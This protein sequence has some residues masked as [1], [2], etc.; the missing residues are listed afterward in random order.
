MMKWF[1]R[2][3]GKQQG[4]GAASEVGFDAAAAPDEGPEALVGA[5]LQPQPEGE[6]ED[7]TGAEEDRDAAESLQDGPAATEREIPERPESGRFFKRL[8][9]RFSGVSV[10]LSAC[11][12]LLLTLG[13]WLQVSANQGL[14]TLIRRRCGIGIPTSDAAPLPLL[15]PGLTFEPFHHGC[16][17]ILLAPWECFPDESKY[18]TQMRLQQNP[19]PA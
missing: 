16:L 5:D 18:L 12:V 13:L 4:D 19:P 6:Q 8:R 15:F 2:K 9:Q 17:D 7:L 10:F 3:P 1:K 11:K 14:R